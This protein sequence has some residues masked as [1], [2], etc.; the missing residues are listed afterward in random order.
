MNR[1]PMSTTPQ[2][3]AHVSPI[4]LFAKH[5]RENS[6]L[7]GLSKIFRSG[8]P[9]RTLQGYS[10]VTNAP[11]RSFRRPCVRRTEVQAVGTNV[12][13]MQW[14]V[15]TANVRRLVRQRNVLHGNLLPISIPVSIVRSSNRALQQ[16]SSSSSCGRL[17]LARQKREEVHFQEQAERRLSAKTLPLR[18]YGSI[19]IRTTLL[20]RRVS[21]QA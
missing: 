1:A 20:Y 19:P 6:S 21:I 11:E 14:H 7:P 9:L 12:Q 15:W 2:A 10:S 3:N 8:S 13:A 5:K 17:M 4:M 18:K 16:I